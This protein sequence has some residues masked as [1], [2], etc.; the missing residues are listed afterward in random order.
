[1]SSQIA[2]RYDFI[3]RLPADSNLLLHG[4]SWDDYEELVDSVGEAGWLRICYDA[5]RL[6]IMTL[7]PEH[8]KYQL[9]IHNMV[10]LL[11][12]RLRIKVSSFGSATMKNPVVEKAAESDGCFYVQTAELIGS[13]V[14][15]DFSI[16][17]P[18]VVVEVDLHHESLSKFP[19][20]AALG[21][22]EIWRYDAKSLTMYH[23]DGV[24]YVSAPSSL[25]LPMLTPEVLTEFLSLSQK[26]DQYETLLAFEDWLGTQQ[27]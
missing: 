9:L 25:A 2:T 4:V 5:G 23:L 14:D 20:Y 27:A 16:D 1:M 24:K 15:I 22:P 8:E 11:S 19:I 6:Q 3:E 18:D 10:I 13:R 12:L 21:V 26:V 7:S 17:P